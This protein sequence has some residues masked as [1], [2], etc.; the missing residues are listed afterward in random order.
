[1]GLS[2]QPLSDYL[3]VRKTEAKNSAGLFLAAPAD[4]AAP[5]Y[6]EVLSIGPGRPSDYTGTPIP[7]PDIK[8][9]DLV[10]MHGGGG[11]RVALEGADVFAIQPRDLIAVQPSTPTKCS[12]GTTEGCTNC[13][14]HC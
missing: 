4:P 8:V 10:L 3:F 14:G 6:A 1:M 12:C 13:K 5:R 11:I 7:M 9:G 2:T